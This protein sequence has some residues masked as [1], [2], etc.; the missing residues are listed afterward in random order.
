MG[1]QTGNMA[2]VRDAL[3]IQQPDTRLLRE[4]QRFPYRG[5][6]AVIIRAR[7][8]QDAADEFRKRN[9]SAYWP[10]YVKQVPSGI[11]GGKR[12]HRVT[13]SAIVPGLIFCPMADEE[14]FLMAVHGIPYVVNLLRREQGLPAILRNVDIEKLR[15]IEAHE[16]LPPDINPVHNF[17]IGQKVR[18]TDEE[19][20]QWPPGKII[21]LDDDGRISIEVYLLGRMVP[22]RGILPSQIEAA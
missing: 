20:V 15:R 12:R 7:K 5:W 21:E 3:V 22:I 11:H 13:F 18:F 6:Y 4:Q 1:N 10:N 8:E 17:K 9:V 2:Q 19:P 14:L 16:N